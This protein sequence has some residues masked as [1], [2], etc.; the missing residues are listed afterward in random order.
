MVV[1]PFA[2][3]GGQYCYYGLTLSRSLVSIQ[4]A[5]PEIGDA[6]FTLISPIAQYACGLQ[7]YNYSR[8]ITPLGINLTMPP[9]DC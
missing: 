3:N 9:I 7:F 8:R 2:H 5:R 1:G 6:L 4:D